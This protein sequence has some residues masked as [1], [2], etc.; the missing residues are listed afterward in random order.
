MNAARKFVTTLGPG[1]DVI[2]TARALEAIETDENFI[3]FEV[4]GKNKKHLNV[5][6]R[7]CPSE[8]VAL[9]QIHGLPGAILRRISHTPADY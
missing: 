5:L 7:L 1:A 8:E 9:H 4:A 2:A 6:L 3:A